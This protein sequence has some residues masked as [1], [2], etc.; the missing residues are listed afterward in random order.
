MSKDNPALA[1]PSDL[2]GAS[3]AAAE[4]EPASAASGEQAR[5]PERQRELP[6]PMALELQGGEDVKLLEDQVFAD[7]V[8]I[9]RGE[10][11]RA[12]YPSSQAA[13][14]VVHFKRVGPKL[15]VIPERLL[16]VV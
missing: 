4:A 12:L 9:R 3:A 6:P 8:V 15:R 1:K 11:G 16:Q 13:C 7:K 10:R 14:W 5:S 2:G